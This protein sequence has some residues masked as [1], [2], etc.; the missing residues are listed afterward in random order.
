MDGV[1][2]A[3][4]SSKELCVI[5]MSGKLWKSVTEYEW[6]GRTVWVKCKI[7]LI[8][9]YVVHAFLY[10]YIPVNVKETKGKKKRETF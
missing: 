3:G 9:Y 7:G 5:S 10:V 4:G 8:K 6:R 1:V 2:W